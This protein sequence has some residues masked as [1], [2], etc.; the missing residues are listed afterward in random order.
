MRVVPLT[1]EAH[2]IGRELYSHDGDTGL[3]LDWVGENVNVVN[4]TAHAAVVADLHQRVLG[5][6]QLRPVAAVAAAV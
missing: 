3:Y 4:E 6:I 5:Y 2:I 1:D